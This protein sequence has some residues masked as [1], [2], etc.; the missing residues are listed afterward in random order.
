MLITF[1]IIIVGLLVPSHAYAYLDPGSGSMMLQLLLA[2]VAG[3]G[4]FL[5]LYWRRL[6]GLFGYGTSS[7][8]PDQLDN[9]DNDQ[10]QK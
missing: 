4:M 10:Q 2:G 3:A 7:N 9:N 5:K 8:M 6:I 1:A